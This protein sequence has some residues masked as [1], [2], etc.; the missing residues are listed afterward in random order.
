[1]KKNLFIS[2]VGYFKTR[3]RKLRVTLIQLNLFKNDNERT[4]ENIKQQIII[5]RLY[6]VL[7]TGMIVFPRLLRFIY[8]F[9]LFYQRPFLFWFYSI[10]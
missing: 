7:L 6:M 5:T 1:M 9:S 3:A 2:F 8:N 10:C 4:E